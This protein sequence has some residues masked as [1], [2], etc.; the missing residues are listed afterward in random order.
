M[1]IAEALAEIDRLVAENTAMVTTI[2]LLRSE[3]DTWR[4][5]SG[6]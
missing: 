2:E 6:R 1:T 3:R 4:S 5:A